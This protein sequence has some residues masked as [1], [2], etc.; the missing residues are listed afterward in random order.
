MFKLN[1]FYLIGVGLHFFLFAKQKRKTPY[2]LLG[3]KLFNHFLQFLFFY[4]MTKQQ[5]IQ[6]LQK[7]HNAFI[8]YIETLTTEEFLYAPADKWTTAQQLDHIHKSIKPL[9]QALGYPKFVPRLLFG[10]ANRP[11]KT[12]DEL[13]NRYNEKL[14]LGGRASS[15]FVP[16]IINAD[17]KDG[18]IKLI[19]ASV[20]KMCKHIEKCSEAALDNLILPHPL[21]GK[22]TIREMLY[23][24]AYHV[25][26]HQNI[27][28]RDLNKK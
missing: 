5:I 28:K 26:H 9:T 10:K 8:N 6:I 25:E 16:P 24:T 27:I 2:R 23:F 12:F 13:V 18:L 15:K 1:K 22:I 11:S 17:K 20:I 14:A 3:K 19:Q 21:L 7:N 4:K